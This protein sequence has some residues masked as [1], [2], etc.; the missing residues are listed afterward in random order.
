LT[1]QRAGA[2]RIGLS[3]STD[4][5]VLVRKPYKKDDEVGYY[6]PAKIAR[7]PTREARAKGAREAASIGRR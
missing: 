7:R 1:S 3:F 2:F 6:D 4:G 5:L